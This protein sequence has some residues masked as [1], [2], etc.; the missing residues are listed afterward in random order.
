MRNPHGDFIWYELMTRDAAAAERFYGP[1]LGWKIG[2]SMP[3]DVD[4]RMIVAGDENAGGALTLTDEMCEHG[5]HPTWLAYIGVDDVD[6]TVA[7]IEQ[8]GGSVLMPA[9]DYPGVGRMAMVSDPQ[10][11]PFY[12][13]RGLSDE[14]STVFSVEKTGHVAWNELVTS[15]L[16]AAKTFYT[17]V[18]GWSLGGAMPMGPLGDYQFLEHGGQMIGAMM[19]SPNEGQRGW[20]FAFNCADIDGAVGQISTLGGTVRDGPMEVPGGQR[21]IQA[22][23]P[24]GTRFMLVGK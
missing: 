23:D 9:T 14:T 22:T 21:V 18:F 10:G 24:E 3:G 13:M 8:K 1:I 20:N 17:E 2:E 12:V 16:G 5:A 6:A 7:Q 15:D 4:Y 11:L 19:Q